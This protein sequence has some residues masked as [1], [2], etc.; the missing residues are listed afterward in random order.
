MMCDRWRRRPINDRS[1]SVEERHAR[2]NDGRSERGECPS[3]QGSAIWPR[4]TRPRWQAIRIMGHKVPVPVR[5][6]E[7]RNVVV[8]SS[9]PTDEAYARGGATHRLRWRR[10]NG[11][12][13]ILV[14]I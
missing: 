9:G 11:Q 12:T 4:I 14:G 13:Q 2:K 10:S 8:G 3:H 5:Y 1:A 7:R 6:Q